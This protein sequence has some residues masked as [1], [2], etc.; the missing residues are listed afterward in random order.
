MTAIVLDAAQF[1]HISN[2]HTA[3]YWSLCWP[4]S[5]ERGKWTKYEHDPLTAGNYLPCSFTVNAPNCPAC[6]VKN[7]VDPL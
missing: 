6:L 5:S 4:T 1:L 7:T 3:G 2:P